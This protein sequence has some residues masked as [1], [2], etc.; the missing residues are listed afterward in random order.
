M[1]HPCVSPPGHTATTS[2]PVREAGREEAGDRRVPDEVFRRLPVITEAPVIAPR[3]RELG[4][5]SQP[6]HDVSRDPG[7]LR[8]R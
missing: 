5:P 8:R 1:Y 6:L 3:I 4:N 2:H 7:P